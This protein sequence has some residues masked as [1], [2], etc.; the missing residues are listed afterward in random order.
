[1]VAVTCGDDGVWYRASGDEQVAF[2]PAFRV[3]VVDSTGCG[4]VFHGAYALG[5][6]GGMDVPERMRFAAATAAMKATKPGGQAG[7]PDWES[8]VAFLSER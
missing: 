8:V 5:L 7:I 6:A 3:E 2:L 4:D 1:M